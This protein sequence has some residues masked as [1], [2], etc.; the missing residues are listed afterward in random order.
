VTHRA[1]GFDH[2]LG[3]H[4]GALRLG[5]DVFEWA[6]CPL[7]DDG[8]AVTHFIGLEDDVAGRPY[9]GAPC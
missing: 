5:A 4:R 2:P 7:A 1:A 6:I 3:E 8:E 9:L